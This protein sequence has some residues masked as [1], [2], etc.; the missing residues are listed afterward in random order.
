MYTDENGWVALQ[1]LLSQA[2]EVLGFQDVTIPGWE[3]VSGLGSGATSVVF[4]AT[5]NNGQAAVCKM[6]TSRT[7]GQAQRGSEVHALRVLSDQP[8]VVPHL[9]PDT[10]EATRMQRPECACQDSSR[11]DNP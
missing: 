5:A 4:S 2:D 6:Y 11:F 9:V 1:T 8:N 10:P 3:L 7:D